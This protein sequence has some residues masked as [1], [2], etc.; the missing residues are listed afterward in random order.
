MDI[1]FPTL[2][3]MMA[4]NLCESAGKDPNH[5]EPGNCPVYPGMDEKKYLNADYESEFNKDPN[6]SKYPPDD[7]Y[8]GDTICYE[9]RNHIFAAQNLLVL[10]Q[11]MNS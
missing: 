2:V 5:G 1:E 10:F 6:D 3:E 7:F 9:W 11:K 4:R 8:N